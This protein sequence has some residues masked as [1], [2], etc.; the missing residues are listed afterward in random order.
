MID[1]HVVTMVAL[2]MLDERVVTMCGDN[3]GTAY[4]HVVTMCGDNGTANA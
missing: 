2:Q 4:E 3:V 1:G